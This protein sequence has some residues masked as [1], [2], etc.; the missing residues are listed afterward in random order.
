MSK[1]PDQ[2]TMTVASGQI[3]RS[4]RLNVLDRTIRKVIE[5][6]SVYFDCPSPTWGWISL[7]DFKRWAHATRAKVINDVAT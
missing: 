2:S 5:G 3:W 7:S 1:S 4:P 6:E